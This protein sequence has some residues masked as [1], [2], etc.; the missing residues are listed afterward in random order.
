MLI[1]TT[2]SN[3]P[4]LLLILTF[5][6]IIAWRQILRRDSETSS[7]SWL[8]RSSS[9][10]SSP[11]N[12]NN[13]NNS[14]IDA[15]DEDNTF[16]SSSVEM[17]YANNVN[18]TLN[19]NP[20][21]VGA[22]MPGVLTLPPPMPSQP[23]SLSSSAAAAS[24]SSS[25]LNRRQ[26]NRMPPPFAAHQGYPVSYGFGVSDGS[27]SYYPDVPGAVF[28]PPGFACCPTGCEFLTFLTM[29]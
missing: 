2:L 23:S 12:H 3:Y 19:V 14:N 25:P 16:D 22:I 24:S 9:I 13:N 29:F 11:I 26:R 7:S 20:E 4:S 6:T 1:I 5:Q 10:M 27:G 17:S 28:M 21:T 15:D 8:S 18:H